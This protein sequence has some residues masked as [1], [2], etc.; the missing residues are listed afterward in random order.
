MLGLDRVE[1]ELVDPARGGLEQVHVALDR[2]QAGEVPRVLDGAIERVHL[3]LRTKGLGTGRDVRGLDPRNVETV[4]GL[5]VLDR[6]GVE[7]LDASE[8]LL[9]AVVATGAE[10]LL[11]L[12]GTG[13][14]LPLRTRRQLDDRGP[15]GL[16]A[17]ER[18][19][20]LL[21]LRGVGGRPPG[22][23]LE[24]DGLGD[25]HRLGGERGHDDRGGRRLVDDRD[26][27][28]GDRL[29]LRLRDGLLAHDRDAL[30]PRCRRL[31]DAGGG[32]LR[33][34]GDHGGRVHVLPVAEDQLARPGRAGVDVAVR[35]VSALAVHLAGQGVLDVGSASGCVSHVLSPVGFEGVETAG[36]E[37]D[38][39]A[40]ICCFV[41][42][43][44][45]FR[46]N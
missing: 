27:R 33:G 2:G 31:G 43:N 21:E 45:V 44:K 41:N 39:I 15:R 16:L 36:F 17:A 25:R 3:V 14:L 13:H 26:D 29:G 12:V 30:R 32:R 22:R 46:H 35:P 40:E 38:S 42:E 18:L 5:G 7:L 23:R 11:L 6:A 8:Q 1:T 10:L 28:G 4:A 20:E 9:L 34:T 37:L 19:G 24:L